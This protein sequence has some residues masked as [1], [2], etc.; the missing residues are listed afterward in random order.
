LIQALKDYD[1]KNYVGNKKYDT[2]ECLVQL[3]HNFQQ[4]QSWKV[5]IKKIHDLLQD[6]GMFGL[7][8]EPGNTEAWKKLLGDL[9]NLCGSD[10]F[11]DVAK[12]CD[13]GY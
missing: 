1:F 2:M 11:S 5:F 4:Y 7:I 3:F 13:A 12:A 6:Q 9:T 8:T 10:E